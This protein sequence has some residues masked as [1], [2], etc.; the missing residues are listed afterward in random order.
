MALITVSSA[1]L[2]KATAVKMLFH[3]L[4]WVAWKL[5]AVLRLHF[6]ALDAIA[7]TPP[8][9]HEHSVFIAIQTP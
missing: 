7:G 2:R 3:A 1:G 6:R 8:T 4:L 9:I 5:L